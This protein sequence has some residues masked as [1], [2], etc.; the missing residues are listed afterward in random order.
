MRN[1][2][3]AIVKRDHPSLS[4]A[5]AAAL[6]AKQYSSAANAILAGTLRA[7]KAAR[8]LCHWG[9]YGEAGLCSFN[10]WPCAGS[11]AAGEAGAGEPLCGYDHPTE[12]ASLRHLVEQ[13]KPIWEASDSLFP[14]MYPR[15]VTG[16]SSINNY[17]CLAEHLSGPHCLNITLEEHRAR[18]RSIVAQA[19]RAADGVTKVVPYFWQFCNSAEFPCYANG[20]FALSQWGIEASLHLPYELGADGLVIWVDVEERQRITELTALATHVTGPLGQQL[21]TGSKTCSSQHCSSHGRCH[22]LPPSPPLPPLPPPSPPPGCLKHCSDTPC[23]AC[24]TGCPTDGKACQ[25]PSGRDA[26]RNGCACNA[27]QDPCRSGL[28]RFRSL[29]LLF[30]TCPLT[31][32]V[33]RRG[34]LTK[35]PGPPAPPSPPRPPR[36]P[37]SPT[38]GC[39][40]KCSDTPCGSCATGCPTDSKPCKLPSGH[41]SSRNECLCNKKRDRCT[42][43]LTKCP[44][45]PPPLPRGSAASEQSNAGGVQCVCYHGYSG[46]S[47]EQVEPRAKTD[48]VSATKPAVIFCSPDGADQGWIDLQHLRNRS[49]T[50]GTT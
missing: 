18:I 31:E 33:I 15:G 23:G 5:E 6:A 45:P 12:G 30:R 29:T 40:E 3:I 13:Q 27:H 25:L 34:N 1:Y 10:Y 47:C 35:C 2:S 39:L 38:P 49:A 17:R 46:R 4:G 41:T 20:S 42:G 9:Y 22:P 11:R 16:N 36:P 7:A 28:P 14:E 44:P 48:D 8:P 43:P 21:L 32:G 37:P 24:A 26:S 19:V 50:A